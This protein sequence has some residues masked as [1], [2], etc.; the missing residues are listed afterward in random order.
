MFLD[1]FRVIYFLFRMQRYSHR[2]LCAAED[3]QYYLYHAEF[4][5]N[6]IEEL[7]RRKGYPEE[8]TNGR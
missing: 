2:A 6:K 8:A 4:Y 5:K 7:K 1:M 3:A